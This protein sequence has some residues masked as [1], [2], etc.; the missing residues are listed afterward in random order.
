MNYPVLALI[1]ANIIWGLSPPIFKLA[2][3]D[4]P[5]FTLA[6]I[7]FVGAALIFLPAAIVTWRKLSFGDFFLVCLTGFLG[8]V[9]NITFF[10][11]G[12]KHGPSIN[13]SIIGTAGPVVLFLM[14]VLFLHE[15]PNKKV[16][17]GMLLALFGVLVIVISPTV[18]DGD[19]RFVGEN[20]LISNLFYVVAVFGSVLAPVVAKKVLN[21]VNE[22]QFIFINF[23]F[24]SICF[25]FGAFFELK[26]W[27]LN[28][29]DA[30]GQLGIIFGIFFASAIA[31]FLFFWA[32]KRIAAQEIGVFAYIDPIASLLLAIPLLGEYP[33]S[34]YLLGAALVLGGIFVA[35]G[36]LH[37]HPIHRLKI[38][39]GE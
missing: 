9:V 21:R 14:A 31:Y 10:F 25:S 23:V 18:I 37:W 30:R 3:Q 2:L 24:A 4:V 1:I 34:N 39:N 26:N 5:P 33:T 8:M 20:V 32:T 17:S 15:R 38:K 19:K 22:Y 13:A 36:R 27:S 12:L 11:F 29:I 6:L 35:E 28:Y 7:R 16:F